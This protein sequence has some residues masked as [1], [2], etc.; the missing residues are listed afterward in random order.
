LALARLQFI[1]EEGAFVGWKKCRAGVI[2]K[3]Q[4]TE[5]AKRSHAAE[6]K[7]RASE[8]LVLEVIGAEE[9]L[10][11]HDGTVVYRKG[12]TVT[13]KDAFC[14][15]RWEVCASGIHFFL[16]RKEAEEFKL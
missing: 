13:P 5:S 12:E 4:I 16:T 2:V 9:G 10:S 14:D 15:N 6:R 1:P 7:C 11:S 8:V 3:L